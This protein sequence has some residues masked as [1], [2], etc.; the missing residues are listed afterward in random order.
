MTTQKSW[1]D[2]LLDAAIQLAMNGA[3]IACCVIP[4]VALVFG[5]QRMDFWWDFIFPTIAVTLIDCFIVKRRARRRKE[6]EN[7]DGEL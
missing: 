7:P 6:R 1:V 3:L 4:L 5:L 2:V